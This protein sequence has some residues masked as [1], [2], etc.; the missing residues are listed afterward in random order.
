M[1]AATRLALGRKMLAEELA[2][3]ILFLLAAFELPTRASGDLP[4]DALYR[5]MLQDKKVK[6]GKI[7]FVLPTGIGSC[8][9]VDDLSENEIKRAIE[10]LAE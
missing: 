10:G 9:F 7:T 1:V 3:R 6:G 5:A 2:G 4:V 8:T